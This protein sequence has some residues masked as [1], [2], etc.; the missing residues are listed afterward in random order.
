MCNSIMS[1]FLLADA[2]GTGKTPTLHGV[3]RTIKERGLRGAGET[4][5]MPTLVIVPAA[6]IEKHVTDLL[7]WFPGE[8]QCCVFH[9]KANDFG[10]AP[11]VRDR[12]I[13]FPQLCALMFRASEQCKTGSA[14]MVGT[15]P[16]E[17]I[18]AP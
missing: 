13:D 3:I 15:E 6:L 12:I 16:K 5:I 1:G 2:T 9:G 4:M 10:H 17:V 11:Q 14:S 18:Y 7:A 8:F